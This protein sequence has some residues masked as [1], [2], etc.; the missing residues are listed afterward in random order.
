MFQIVIKVLV[1]PFVLALQ[2]ELDW[3]HQSFNLDEELRKQLEKISQEQL[4]I[5]LND[6]L[7]V[8]V[9]EV[10]TKV[11]EMAAQIDGIRK[12]LESLRD[13]DVTLSG[14]LTKLKQDLLMLK[15]TVRVVNGDVPQMR[16]VKVEEVSFD[17]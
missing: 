13:M 5:L 1:K 4:R 17:G 6:K 9:F 7:A 8:R 3:V 2:K 16:E 11:S 10:D 12:Y 14:H 15:R